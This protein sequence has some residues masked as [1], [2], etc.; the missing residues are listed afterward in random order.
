LR[1]DAVTWPTTSATD[2]PTFGAA[3]RALALVLPPDAVRIRCDDDRSPELDSCLRDVAPGT[4]V[5]VATRRLGSRR[6][7]R[8]AMRRQD[9]VICGEYLL[10]PSF[11]CPVVVVEDCAEALAWVWHNFATVPPGATST[12]APLNLGFA[13]ARRLPPRM[14][15]GLIW[16]RVTV[17]RRQ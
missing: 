4:V 5:A 11:E 8:Q 2:E 9:V 13:L 12:A 7:V 17:G 1:G 14:L 16:S 10:L 15:S 3:A 6:R